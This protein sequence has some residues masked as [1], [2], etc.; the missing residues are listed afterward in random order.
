[1][2]AVVVQIQTDSAIVAAN[3]AKKIEAAQDLF[4]TVA[5]FEKMLD[6]L[7]DFIDNPLVKQALIKQG[8]KRKPK[9]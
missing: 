4:E 8:I 6:K 1:M 9:S 2:K 7:P 3:I 5:D